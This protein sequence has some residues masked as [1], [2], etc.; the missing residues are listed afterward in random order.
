MIPAS[1]TA[2]I[3]LWDMRDVIH[4]GAPDQAAAL[5]RPYA[6]VEIGAAVGNVN[7]N[8]PEL[9]ERVRLLQPSGWTA[10]RELARSWIT[11]GGSVQRFQILDWR[12]RRDANSRP[13]PSEGSA[14]FS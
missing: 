5:M 1:P 8:R 10:R 13:L 2:A 12:I 14:L 4:R 7:N 11:A 6:G 3:Y 9:I